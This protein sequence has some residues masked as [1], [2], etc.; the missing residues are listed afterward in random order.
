MV[1]ITFFLKYLTH[2]SDAPFSFGF[3]IFF[4]ALVGL[5]I[6]IYIRPNSDLDQ[7]LFWF[8]G[9]LLILF[10][11]L[12]PLGTGIDA[13]GYTE[14]GKTICPWIDCHQLIQTSRDQIWFALSGALK[15][16][17]SWERS[18]LFVSAI[19][20]LVQ[21]Y[22]ID[23]LCR[24]KLLSLTLYVS[25]VYLVFDITILRAG[26]A[27]SWYFLAFYMFSSKRNGVG[28]LLILTNFLVH[29]QA[30][31]SIAL[32]PFYWL[33][34]NKKVAF[35]IFILCLVGIY[36]PL[37]PTSAQLSTLIPIPSAKIYIDYALGGG[38]L[39]VKP[40]PV[41]GYFMLGY[42]VLIVS[43]QGVESA[44]IRLIRF[45]LASALMGTFFAWFFTPVHDIQMRLFDFYIAP[46]IFIA[47]NLKRNKYLFMA[48]IT[49]ATLLYIRYEVMHDYIIG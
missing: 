41:A 36:S 47:G 1:E 7:K 49:L 31:F 18:I 5:T 40:F 13:P 23:R 24:Q 6:Y 8:L 10:S 11:A 17:F 34:E 29:S 22:C 27:L 19:G 20:V 37:H 46:L 38:Y 21:L 2:L 39:G 15:S 35:A 12:R 30:L 44:S 28:V 26:F 9:L 3:L 25:L 4:I 43:T 42:L 16:F 33:A 48:T 32:A 14:M 45:V